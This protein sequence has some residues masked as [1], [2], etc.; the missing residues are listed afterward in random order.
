MVMVRGGA[1]V[2][3]GAEGAELRLK[4]VLRGGSYG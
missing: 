4:V 2:E 3:G 1:A